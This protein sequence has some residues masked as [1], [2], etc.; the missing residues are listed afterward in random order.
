MNVMDELQCRAELIAVLTIVLA[1]FITFSSIITPSI[2][3]WAKHYSDSAYRI[4]LLLTSPFNLNEFVGAKVGLLEAIYIVELTIIDLLSA[5]ALVGIRFGKSKHIIR[6]MLFTFLIIIVANYLAFI[7]HYLTS[8]T[9]LI[10]ISGIAVDSSVIILMV[11]L[12]TIV[13]T[14][15]SPKNPFNNNNLVRSLI[16]ATIILMIILHAA[17]SIQPSCQYTGLIM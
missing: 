4:A 12:E 14:L 10:G 17:R 1:L 7:I 2:L 6:N 11:G 5:V 13:L 3:H 16:I 8:R 15:F 9:P